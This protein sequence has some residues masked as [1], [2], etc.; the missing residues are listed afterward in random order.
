MSTFSRREIQRRLNGVAA[1][2]SGRQVEDLVGR[3]N[4]K[5][6]VV[7]EAEWELMWLSALSDLGQLKHE[8]ALGNGTR[9]I[10]CVFQNAA[11]EF[12]A[13]ITA[14]SDAGYD[15]DNPIE[16]LRTALDELYLKHGVPSGFHLHVES[17]MEGE[18]RD[19]KVHL[20]LP[21]RGEIRSFVKRNFTLLMKGIA[22]RPDT[23]AAHTAAVDGGAIRISYDPNKRGY[24]T[25]GGHLSFNVPYSLSRNPLTH[26]LKGKKRQLKK[27]GWSGLRGIIVCDA[28]CY[29]LTSNT[30]YS[31]ALTL[32]QIVG[33]FLRQNRSID[34][35]L[36]V[37]V[38]TQW[39]HLSRP[40][41]SLK[42]FSRLIPQPSLSKDRLNSLID[43]LN[44]ALTTFPSIE[45]NSANAVA[46]ANSPVPIYKDQTRFFRE[47][48]FTM[49]KS[50]E[51]AEIRLSARSLAALLG[52]EM[53][54]EMFRQGQRI[55]SN[56]DGK[57]FEFFQAMVR[58]GRT[59]IE[60]RVERRPSED[61]DVIV[62]RFGPPD[63]AAS[64]FQTPSEEK[65]QNDSPD[66]ESICF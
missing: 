59:I 40:Q 38:Q 65:R 32:E 43:V 12:A 62:I 46:L 63:A 37:G 45:R 15:E 56:V 16:E 35:V 27:S 52:G 47:W 1:K 30:G 3:L 25:G 5:G 20:L 39:D 28:D 8:P 58:Q 36:C 57:S 42:Y 51:P 10:D 21:K 23:A 41:I 49:G 13:D 6:R 55:T 26:A 17:K 29:I 66:S 60:T 14:V 24:N 48:N 4:Q 53:D 2:L 9:R 18:F 44:R 33:D 31:S 22:A 50:H 64:K 61:D 34:F 19:Q 54:F 11:I 7:L